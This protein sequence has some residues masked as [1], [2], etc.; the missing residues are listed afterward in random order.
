MGIPG[1][2]HSLKVNAP[3][4]IR[5]G[6]MN[7][8]PGVRYKPIKGLGGFSWIERIERKQRRSKFG[9]KTIDEEYYKLVP[10]GPR[11]KYGKPWVAT[12]VTWL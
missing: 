4:I 10:T 7:D 5:G 3:V 6:R 8:V 1:I 9:V 12:L 11:S 2:G